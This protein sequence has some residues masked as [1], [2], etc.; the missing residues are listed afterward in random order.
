[1]GRQLL[2]VQAI[3]TGSG[4]V[5]DLDAAK[6]A[7]A[8]GN[9]KALLLVNPHNPTGR[10]LRRDELEAL[11]ELA[12][13]HDLVV[14]SDEIH[15]DLAL[16]GATHVPFASLSEPLAAR[17]VT[18]Y[19]ASKSYNLGG[20]CCAL[21]HI[22]PGHVERELAA[23]PSQLLGHISTLAVAACRAAWSPEGDAWLEDCLARLRAN[24]SLLAGWLAA[25]GAA[26]VK[27]YPPEGTYLAWLDFRGAGLGDSPGP[28]LRREAKVLMND[29]PDFGPGGAGFARLNFATTGDILAEVLDRVAV[30]LAKARTER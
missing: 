16:T 19:S 14:I 27:C 21:A 24:H 1:M 29:G 12:E 3:D 23:P 6:A 7:A 8:S 30:A 28:W 20:L 25:E 4:W 9:A 2:P 17:T 22:G 15:A 5:F 13:L 11:G 18:L 26:R 10:M